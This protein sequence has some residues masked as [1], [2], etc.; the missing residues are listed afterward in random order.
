M[1][2]TPEPVLLHH[3]NI[4]ASHVFNHTNIYFFQKQS[5]EMKPQN[6][7]PDEMFQFEVKPKQCSKQN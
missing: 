5:L 3:T 4:D 2:L 7:E 6:T 1:D